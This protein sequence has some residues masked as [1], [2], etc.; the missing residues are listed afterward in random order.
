VPVI[1]SGGVSSHE[2]LERI[3]A[4]QG[5]GIAGVICGR[6]LYDGRIDAARALAIMAR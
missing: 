5:S 1:A 6:A 4:E 2:D 3:K